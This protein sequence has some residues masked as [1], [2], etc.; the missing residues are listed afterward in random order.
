MITDQVEPLLGMAQCAGARI[1]HSWRAD[2]A[3]LT[4]IDEWK[5]LNGNCGYRWDATVSYDQPQEA[6]AGVDMPLP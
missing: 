3:R 1:M 4:L 2:M 5:C 6:S